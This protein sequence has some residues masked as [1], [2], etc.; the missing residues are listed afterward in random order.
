M[1]CSGQ[2]KTGVTS[3][4]RYFRPEP[5]ARLVARWTTGCQLLNDVI[6]LVVFVSTPTDIR[7]TRLREREVR[8]FGAEAITEGCWRSHYED[9][10]R[11]GRGRSRHEELAV[12][13]EVSP[14]PY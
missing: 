13:I 7:L 5:I 9:G 14:T 6:D 1:R 12:D 10:T 2:S 8:H 4:A 11:E 3:C